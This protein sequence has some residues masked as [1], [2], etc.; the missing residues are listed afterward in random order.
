M[1]HDVILFLATFLASAVEAVEALT[2]VLAVGVVRGWR[3]TLIGVGAATLVLAAV[4]AALGPA[5]QHIPIGRSSLRRRR[6]CCSPSACSG[7]AR[8]SSVRAA[9]SRCTTRPRRSRA[10]ARRPARQRLPARPGS[11]GTRSRSRSRACCSR[12]SRSPSSWSPSAAT[13]GR[14][15]LAAAAAAAAGRPRRRCGAAG[16]RAA[17]AR[18][19]EHAQVR[20]RGAAHELRDLLGRRGRGRRMAG[21]RRRD[22][23]RSSP[24]SRLLSLDPRT[25][26]SAGGGSLT[27][28]R[29]HGR[30]V[31]PR[32]SAA[33]GGTSSSATT[34]GSRPASP[35]LSH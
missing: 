13:Q 26:R 28:L 25:R 30:E 8:R 24:T 23:R 9:S 14:L 1:S 22:P 31:R 5:L 11:T 21:R 19:R 12:G 34:G 4:V 17:R 7:C 35:S 32:R 29:G 3:S 15:G 2:I 16:A 27:S 6:A 18:A 10:S 33:S 20:R